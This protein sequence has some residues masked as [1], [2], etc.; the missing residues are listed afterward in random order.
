MKIQ[1]I[2]SLCRKPGRYIGREKN[3]FQKSWNQ[4]QVRAACIFPDLYEIGMSHLGLQI[5]YDIINR[6]PWA[7]SDRAYCPDTDLEEQLKRFQHPLF[8]L[9]TR[10]PLSE[11][12]CLLI[13]LPYELCYSNIFTI[14]D[15]AGIPVWQK[16]RMDGDWPLV[17]GGGSCCLNP[18]PVADLFD[19]IVIGDGE[20]AAV[21]ILETVRD[22][23]KAGNSRQ[24]LLERLYST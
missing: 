16:D 20:E 24:G 8:G 4:V 9:E 23:R 6:A 17:V 2:L 19:A 22:Y 14:L 12:D 18:E 3:A 21:D 10:R 15:L 7:L 13:T 5:L 11:F 1:E